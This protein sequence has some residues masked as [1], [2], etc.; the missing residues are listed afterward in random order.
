M[1]TMEERMKI[2]QMV[3]E[4]KITAEDAAGLLEALEEGGDEG[5]VAGIV[6]NEMSTTQGRKPRW[7]RVRVTDTNTGK[8]RVNVRLPMSLVNVGLKMGSRF[9]PEVEGLD[10]DMLS[11]AIASGEVGQIVDVVDEQDGEHVEVFLE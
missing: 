10:M 9:A 8:P 1:A 7:L 3:Q 5:R 6:M 11:E 2:L 4:G